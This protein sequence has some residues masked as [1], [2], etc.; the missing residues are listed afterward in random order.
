MGRILL[1][2]CALVVTGVL[3]GPAAVYG[4][5]ADVAASAT[6][7]SKGSEREAPI[8]VKLV[9]NEDQVTRAA[10]REA[11]SDERERLDLIAQNKAADAAYFAAWASGFGTLLIVFTLVQ[12]S[13]ANMRQMRA[14]VGIDRTIVGKNTATGTP[15]AVVIKNFGLTPAYGF[16]C[17]WAVLLDEKP[18][19][20]SPTY[21]PQEIMPQHHLII[22]AVLST[23]TAPAVLAGVTSFKVQGVGTYRDLAGRRRV[24]KFSMQFDPK[25]RNLVFG[26]GDNH[27][28]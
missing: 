15:Y 4:W 23:V 3:V 6:D 17:Q 2:I 22:E 5:P 27:A 28:T 16:R 7:K 8:A 24:T 26:G 11:K 25:S 21:S 1:S 18:V 19:P 9:E 14:Y 10:E 12:N 13:L 20:G